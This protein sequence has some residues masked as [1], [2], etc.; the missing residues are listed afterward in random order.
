MLRPKQLLRVLRERQLRAVLSHAMRLPVR[1]RDIG[2]VVALLSAGVA[3]GS[4]SSSNAPGGDDGS[5]GTEAGVDS[6]T[7]TGSTTTDGGAATETGIDSATD[8]GTRITD[9][10]TGDEGGAAYTG[11]IEVNSEAANGPRTYRLSAQFYPTATAPT[12]L[13]LGTVVGDC[14][15]FSPSAVDAGAPPMA[16]RAGTIAVKD[17]PSTISTMMPDANSMYSDSSATN[18]GLTWKGG[19]VIAI[20]G[21]GDLVHAFSGQV[22]A[23]ED[24]AGVMPA[25]SLAS[26]ITISL[27]ADFVISWTPST[28]NAVRALVGLTASHSST[29]DVTIQCAAMDAT[30]KVTVPKSLLSSIPQSDS[31]LVILAR[32]SPVTALGDNVS[33][34]IGSDTHAFGIAQFVP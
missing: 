21:S 13:C 10:G 9:G 16:V 32:S 18:A 30:G 20:S 11:F 28:G 27:S 2:V 22:T 14:C 7:D 17:G 5:A 33:I 31:G 26:P 15:V 24:L 34:S 1:K 12:P 8:A 19:D 25:L 3:C 29:K 4:S 6:A 23:V